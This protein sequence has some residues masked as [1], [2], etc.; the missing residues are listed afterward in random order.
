MKV[1]SSRLLN[2]RSGWLG[3]GIWDL[4]VIVYTMIAS[5]AVLQ[6]FGLELLIFPIGG[7]VFLLIL[8]IRLKSRPK[9][10]RD[11]LR[12]KLPRKSL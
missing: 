3:L 1:Q 12:S 4:V 2:E 6:L 9:T 11:Y 10:I 5:N 7:I 8:N